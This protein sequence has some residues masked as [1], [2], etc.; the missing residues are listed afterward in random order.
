MARMLIKGAVVV[1]GLSVLANAWGQATPKAYLQYLAAKP[2][3]DIPRVS[4]TDFGD[5]FSPQTG[6]LQIFV[7]DVSLPGNDKLPVEFSRVKRDFVIDPTVPPDPSD[8]RKGVMLDWEVAIPKI[9]VSYDLA[10][11]WTTSDPGRT[12]K[13]CSVSSKSRIRPAESY[14]GKVRIYWGAPRV[15]IP[16]SA[17]RTLQYNDSVYPAPSSGG[18]YF[19]LTKDNSY[20]SC[21]STIKNKTG[22]EG[23]LMVNQEGT[24]Y[25]FD[26]MALDSRIYIS[27]GAWISEG[28]IHA[29]GDNFN[30]GQVSLYVSKIQDVHGNTVEYTYSNGPNDSIAPTSIIASD[31]RRIDVSYASGRISLVTSNGRSW[32]YQYSGVVAPGVHE[33]GMLSLVTNPDNSTWQYADLNNYKFY[34]IRGGGCNGSFDPRDSEYTNPDFTAGAGSYSKGYSVKNPSGATAIFGLS[35]VMFRR[36]D[37][38]FECWTLSNIVDVDTGVAQYVS[39]E[40]FSVYIDVVGLTYKKISGPGLADRV[41]KYGYRTSG[42]PS[43]KFTETKIVN[44]DGSYELHEYGNTFNYDDGLLLQTKRFASG[45]ISPLSRTTYTYELSAS[46]FPKRLGFDPTVRGESYDDAYH[47]PLK[48]VTEYR[49][50]VGFTWS[51]EQFDAFVRPVRITRSSAPAP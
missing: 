39:Q 34:A 33:P 6:S 38:P 2:P 44:P 27:P 1:L 23:F 36:W 37:V 5:Q 13:N 19:W 16:G 47:R 8:R 31:G 14:W 49:D 46:G 11:G 32:A 9:T 24:K 7:N 51:A 35:K 21:L 45:A 10:D 41:W 48:S 12:T 29:S 18:P 15:D 43:P 17:S 22:V 30:K 42:A 40:R 28:G 25:W 26:W 20:F 4:N 50:G 3:S